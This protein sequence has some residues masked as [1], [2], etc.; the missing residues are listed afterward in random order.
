MRTAFFLACLLSFVAVSPV[1]AEEQLTG[2]IRT[3]YYEVARGVFV[4]ASM[5]RSA[6]AIRWADVDL[7]GR[8]VLVQLPAELQAATGDLVAVRLAEPKSTQTAQIL[9]MISVGR[10]LAVEPESSTG[11]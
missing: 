10:A 9:P 3:I 11:R 4:E 5:K 8:S 1:R 6:A 2:R 7:P